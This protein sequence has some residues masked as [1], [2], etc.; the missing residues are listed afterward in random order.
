MMMANSST[1]I[2]ALTS[3]EAKFCLLVVAASRRVT[4]AVL[5]AQRV[6]PPLPTTAWAAARRAIGTRNGE[7]D[8]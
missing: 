5:P 8:T 7:Q 6:S 2:Q 4:R 3:I 1:H